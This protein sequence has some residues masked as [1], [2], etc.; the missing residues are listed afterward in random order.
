MSKLGK[1]KKKKIPGNLIKNT[2]CLFFFCLT[3]LLQ[4]LWTY[5]VI[6]LQTKSQ[7]ILQTLREAIKVGLGPLRSFEKWFLFQIIIK[8]SKS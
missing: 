3:F 1:K 8:V 4:A 6:V 7:I 2:L 5:V